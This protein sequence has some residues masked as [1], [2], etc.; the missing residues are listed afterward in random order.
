MRLLGRIRQLPEWWN[1]RQ[2]YEK[3]SIGIQATIVSATIVYVFV[4]SLQWGT[5]ISANS[6]NRRALIS[7]Q[8]AFVTWNGFAL[9]QFFRT[10]KSGRQYL[11]E[12]DNN[13]LNAGNTPAVGVVNYFRIADGMLNEPDGKDW[14]R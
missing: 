8:R 7:V 9:R 13:W 10:S 14:I 4:A 6:L 1:H 2:P 11:I 5:M 12:T 3:V